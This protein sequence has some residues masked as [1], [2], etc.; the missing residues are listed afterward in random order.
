MPVDEL[1]PPF[2][3]PRW[4]RGL[5]LFDGEE[6]FEAHEVVEDLWHE[7]GGPGRD[8]LKGF[9]QAAVALEHHRRGNPRGLRSV[10]LTAEAL[11]RRAAP[12]TGGIDA[13]GMAA[14]LEAFRAGVERGE[15][16]PWPRVR[17]I[18]GAG[19]PEGRTG[20]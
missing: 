10:G 5:A 19:A 17:R 4:E 13:A 2:D 11:L 1:R 15:E 18:G 14:D 16:P 7:T 9:I 3:D 20:P 12:G 6:F 8:L